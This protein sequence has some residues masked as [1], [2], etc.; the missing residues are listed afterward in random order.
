M[1]LHVC[2]SRWVHTCVRVFLRTCMRVCV[3]E[4]GGGMCALS[5][6]TWG[7]W[8]QCY[9]FCKCEKI[10][11]KRNLTTQ[12][13]H[14]MVVYFV[15]F[16]YMFE[17]V[18]ITLNNLQIYRLSLQPE[19]SGC[20]ASWIE[21]VYSQPAHAVKI[22]DMHL[23]KCTQSWPRKSIT[24]S[25]S[26]CTHRCTKG[27][28][29]A[30][31]ATYSHQSVWHEHQGHVHN[32]KKCASQLDISRAKLVIG[33]VYTEELSPLSAC[34]LVIKNNSP[35]SAPAWANQFSSI[36]AE[37]STD[38]SHAHI[39]WGQQTSYDKPLSFCHALLV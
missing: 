13:N 27:S 12:I 10:S 32:H 38:L 3:M 26:I 16:L 35:S 23:N 8:E 4:E 11:V 18:C 19:H 21:N 14:S 15:P 34:V 37:A 28:I 25:L 5:V 9:T 24:V 2:M 1:F 33:C 17:L 20:L 29:D 30:M 22:S 31:Q 39:S 6:P 36:Q 7:T